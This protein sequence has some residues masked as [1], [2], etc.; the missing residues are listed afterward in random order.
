MIALAIAAEPTLLIADEPTTALDATLQAEMLDLLQTMRRKLNLSL[1]LITHDLAIVA[2][3]V[4]RVAVMNSRPKSSRD[5]P[6]E[7]SVSDR[8]CI[9]TPDISST[10]VRS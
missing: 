1:L 3:M 7:T 4:D 5:A 10:A 9:R 8:R 2:T 6:A